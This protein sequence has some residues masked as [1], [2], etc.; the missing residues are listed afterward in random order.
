MSNLFISLIG[1]HYLQN[2]GLLE[3]RVRCNNVLNIVDYFKDEIGIED[4]INSTLKLLDKQ[5]YDRLRNLKIIKDYQNNLPKVYCDYHRLIQAMTI[6]ILNS[7]DA[8][9]IKEYQPNETPTLYFKVNVVQGKME[10]ITGDNGCGIP[11]SEISKIF[12]AFYSK[13]GRNQKGTGIGLTQV[14]GILRKHNATYEVK[15]EVNK[16]TEI[17]WCI[18]LLPK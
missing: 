15:S 13:K 3:P 4:I 16:Y 7:L 12:N 5:M 6:Q 1:K 17:K 18:P 9:E 11:S 2:R 10:I 14:S 8:M